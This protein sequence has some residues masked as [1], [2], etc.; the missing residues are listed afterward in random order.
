MET[1]GAKGTAISQVVVVV[2]VVV[3]EIGI[4]N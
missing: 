1:K 3:V 2:V 4:S